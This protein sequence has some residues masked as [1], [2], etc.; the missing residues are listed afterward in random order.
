MRYT[1]RHFTYLLSTYYVVNKDFHYL[2]QG[3]G[4]VT[5]QVGLFVCARVCH[6]VCVDCRVDDYCESNQPISLN[7]GAMTGPIPIGRTD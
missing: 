6:S 7:L 3:G 5:N 1:N 2:R 4:Y